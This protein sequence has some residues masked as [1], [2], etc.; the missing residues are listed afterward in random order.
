[1]QSVEIGKV[2]KK[3]K[4][5][6]VA[7]RIHD[8]ILQS[9][10]SG[11]VDVPDEGQDEQMVDEDDEDNEDDGYVEDGEDGE[12]E[13]EEDAGDAGDTDEGETEDEMFDENDRSSINNGSTYSSATSV[14]TS[15]D[16]SSQRFRPH[17]GYP[18]HPPPVE[19][20]TGQQ[21]TINWPV[22]PPYLASTFV[23]PQTNGVDPSLR[24]SDT[25]LTTK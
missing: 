13:D 6:T 18:S 15:L 22:H 14:S 7:E 20:G 11:L 8:L 10:T 4:A 5:H 23:D 21:M 17:Q 3:A 24:C 25:K 16:T 9:F 12:D 1:M 19:A 2:A